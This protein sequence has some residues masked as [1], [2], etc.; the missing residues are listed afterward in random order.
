MKS[1]H[2]RDMLREIAEEAEIF[3]QILKNKEQY[4]KDFVELYKTHSFKRIYI[5][6]NG[7][8][9]CAS[10]ALKYAANKLL[11]VDATYST[12]GLFL[13]HEGFDPSGIYKSEDMLLICP[14]ESGRTKG[15]VLIARE[16]KKKGI[17]VAC[18]TLEPEGVL[19]Q[20]SDVVIF[21]PSRREFGLPSTKGHSTGIFLFLLAFIEAAYQTGK[22]TVE[23]YES[24]M[25]GMEHLPAAVDVA[26]EK[27]LAWFD[28]YMD[29]A[30]GAGRFHLI[31]YGANFSTVN[32]IVLKFVESHRKP[33]IAVEL[34]EFMHGHIRSITNDEIIVFICAEE[35]V[36][37]QRMLQLYDL[38]TKENVGA[39]RILI[40][41]AKDPFTVPM[42]IAFDASNVEFVNVLE[43]LVPLQI[44]TYEISD[45]LGLDMSKSVGMAL[46]KAMQPSFGVPLTQEESTKEG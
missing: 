8:P 38:L 44:L 32:E 35:G 27:T 20:T 26:Y 33:S 43:Y 42:E 12:P 46:K 41:S 25:A 1:E 45:H 13:H 18:C 21:K 30:M 40:H 23:E 36:E 3:A 29:V 31:G 19:A 14:A 5:V 24:Y 22:L 16:A 37:K 11:Q 34:E 9:G 15:P 6:G 39:A 28:R 17:S 10:I 7:S 2:A 4:I